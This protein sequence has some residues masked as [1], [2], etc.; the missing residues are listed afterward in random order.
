M[1][2][3]PLADWGS[4]RRAGAAPGRSGD[5]RHHRAG[6]PG[7]GDRRRG[8][9]GA[10]GRAL[11]DQPAARQRLSDPVR[12][13]AARPATPAQSST[14][15]AS[16]EIAAAIEA[17]AK[18]AQADMIASVQS[19]GIPANGWSVLLDNIGTYGTSYRQRGDRR[20]RR[21]RRQP[22]GG[23]DLSD[24]LRRWRRPAARR[25]EVLRA[26]FRQGRP[27]AGRRLLVADHVRRRQSFQ[28]PNP[29]DRFALGDRDKLDDEP[30][31]LAR[32]LFRRRLARPGK[33]ANWLPAP[34]SGP[35][36]VTMRLYS[37]RQE[38][39]SG[40]WAPPPIRATD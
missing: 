25:R 12:A 31:R 21:P 8:D 19:I 28:V 20:P 17:G 22:A 24:R 18:A 33:E 37:P 35:F 7:A 16:P 3:T 4:R 39:L 13:R 34:A 15:A 38:A 9:A 30:R 32:H 23:R 5:R 10:A 40:A 36:N 26:A 29:L 2:L 1:T 27:A 6:A 14:P 11:E